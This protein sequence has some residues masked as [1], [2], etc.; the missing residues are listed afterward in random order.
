MSLTQ[1]GVKTAE[2]TPRNLENHYFSVSTE[3]ESV[4]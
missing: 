4:W 1:F 2:Y 3:T